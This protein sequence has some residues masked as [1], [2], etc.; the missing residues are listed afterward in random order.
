VDRVNVGSTPRVMPRIRV[1]VAAAELRYRKAEG[2]RQREYT[3]KDCRIEIDHTAGRV[4]VGTAVCRPPFSR[5]LDVF[6]SGGIVLDAGG[7]GAGKYDLGRLL[8]ALGER[9]RRFASLRCEKGGWG[10]EFAPD[11]V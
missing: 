3:P 11:L 5:I 10:L 2:F 4:S 9:G 8:Y 1:V 6:E 7:V